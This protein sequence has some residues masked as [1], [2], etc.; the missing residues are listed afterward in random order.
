MGTSCFYS[1]VFWPNRFSQTL[2]TLKSLEI[3]FFLSPNNL[4]YGWTSVKII[5][6]NGSDTFIFS[7]IKLVKKTICRNESPPD[8]RA[9]GRQR[10]RRC[11]SEAPN[12]HR[13]L[14]QQQQQRGG[15][16]TSTQGE[17]GQFLDD[18]RLH[19]SH[20]S[21]G[22]SGAASAGSSGSAVEEKRLLTG[23]G[24]DKENQLLLLGELTAAAAG[25][26]GDKTKSGYNAKQRISRARSRR[27]ANKETDLF[28]KI[29][30]VLSQ[31][32]FQTD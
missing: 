24:E 4:F 12:R 11:Q 28:L 25:N 19:N 1:V 16:L 9:R 26:G 32:G 22:S 17:Y 31:Y 21:G 27:V 13:Q 10:A 2:S 3:L 7:Q 29:S 6:L 14:L 23:G 18:Y 20:S 15:L 5:I 8:R 30:N